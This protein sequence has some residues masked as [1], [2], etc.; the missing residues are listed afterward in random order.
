MSVQ[1]CARKIKNRFVSVGWKERRDEMKKFYLHLRASFLWAV[2]QK[3]PSF[4]S[5]PEMGIGGN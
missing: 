3:P 2:M 1:E 4:L 5:G